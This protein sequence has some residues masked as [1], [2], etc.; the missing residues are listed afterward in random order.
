LFH[1][2]VQPMSVHGQC[3]DDPQQSL[4]SRLLIG[5]NRKRSAGGQNDWSLIVSQKSAR[6]AVSDHWEADHLR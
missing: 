4:P 2:L 6:Y 5:V 1:S 3:L